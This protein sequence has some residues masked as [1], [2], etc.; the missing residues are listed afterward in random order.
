MK[1]MRYV[2]VLPLG[3]L[4]LMLPGTAR[5]DTIYSYQSA[6]YAGCSGVFASS[7]TTCLASYSALQVTFDT[8]LSISQL[9]NLNNVNIAAD[10]TSFTFS[11]GTGLLITQA[12][13][14]VTNFT[15][16]TDAS[17]DI[18]YWDVHA[19]TG[20]PS[21]TEPTHYEAYSFNLPDFAGDNSVLSLTETATTFGEAFDNGS[22]L[23]GS[24]SPGTWSGPVTTTANAPEPSTLLLLGAGLLGVMLLS[25]RLAYFA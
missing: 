13:N 22:H 14:P 2:L 16:T 3:L 4:C 5:A 12:L 11:D 8:S 1:T 21:A 20:G 9:E 10:V 15:I 19:T 18:V 25:R 23:G 7:G 17:G 24:S 6:P